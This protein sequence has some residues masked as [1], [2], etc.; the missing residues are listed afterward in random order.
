MRRLG[1]SDFSSVAEVSG[2][3]VLS[4]KIKIFG[5]LNFIPDEAAAGMAQTRHSSSLGGG[6]KKFKVSLETY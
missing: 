5:F 4:V 1:L 3:T 2:P 6:C